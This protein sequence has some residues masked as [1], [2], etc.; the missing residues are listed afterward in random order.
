[1]YRS[2]IFEFINA[3]HQSFKNECFK[4]MTLV[5]LNKKPQQIGQLF[6][7]NDDVI[8]F[9]IKNQY[10]FEKRY[11]LSNLE[12]T[13]I[14]MVLDYKEKLIINYDELSYEIKDPYYLKDLREQDFKKLIII[15]VFETNNIIGVSL[16]YLDDSK[17]DINISNQK[18]LTFYK[19][20]VDSFDD[21]INQKIN[22]LI[23]EEESFYIIVKKNKEEIY[24]LNELIQKHLKIA[25]NIISKKEPDFKKI[26]MFS[27]KMKTIKEKEITIYY[28]SKRNFEKNSG[29]LEI[30]FY[31]Q[32]SI[33]SHGY[34]NELTMIF[35]QDLQKEKSTTML[36]REFL[37]AFKK[38]GLE[39][40]YKFYQIQSNS[41]IILIDKMLSKK[42]ENDLKYILKKMYYLCILMPKDLP[43]GIDLIKVADY[44]TEVL[45]MDFSYDEYRKYQ[46]SINLEKY[47]CIK[48]S[49]N[50]NKIMIKADTLETIGEVISGPIANY[51]NLSTYKL[52]ELETI[53]ILEKALKNNLNAPIFTILVTSINRRKILELLKKVILKYE[54]AKIIFHLPVIMDVSSQ[55]LFEILVKIKQMGFVIIVDSTIFMNLL[56]NNSLRIADAILIRKEEMKESLSCNNP[57]NQKLFKF[58]Y[59]DGK[60]VIFEQIPQEKDASLI[61]ELTCLMI[62][63]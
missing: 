1:M 38:M 21:S 14:E 55:E 8:I 4:Q 44:L 3:N 52:Y 63:R 50:T 5:L 58:Y 2:V 16:I 17:L 18:W 6:D 56:Y 47:E 60:V 62:N 19:K 35:S 54:H 12:G 9:H 40:K 43:L 41:I 30:E 15:P 28:L 51:F 39:I 24:Y 7:N 37:D 11:Q 31:L 33:N 48:T 46:H 10:T 27:S 29:D 25:K 57:Y 49:N 13:I 53:N 36:A 45:P 22:D 59:D 61:N 32:D 26:N 20:I 42:E 23:L 34:K